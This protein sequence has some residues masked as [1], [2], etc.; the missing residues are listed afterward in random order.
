MYR[1]VLI[2]PLM[3][4]AACG[5]HDSDTKKKDAT[6]VVINAKDDDGGKVRITSGKNG[7]K[8]TL[9]GDGVNINFDLPDFAKVNIDSDFDING[10]KLYP[11]SHV[12]SVNVDASSKED[13]SKATVRFGFTSPTTAPTAADWM[14]AEFAKKDM[15]VTRS[16]DV[17]TGV[18]KDGDH[19]TIKFTPDG[20]AA[21]GEVLIIST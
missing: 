5:Q 14:A 2:L 4:L 1:S 15:K 19:F 18:D 20:K 6:E 10:V 12:T 9:N 13:K 16:G 7:G 11:G 3:L 17:L 8:F 21:K